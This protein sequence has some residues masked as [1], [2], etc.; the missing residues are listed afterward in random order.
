[1]WRGRVGKKG[2]WAVEM[3][4]CAGLNESDSHRLKGSGIIGVVALLEEACHWG[5][6]LGFQKLKPATVSLSLPSAF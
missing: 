4:Q 1:M 6:A 2:G 5:Q 3:A